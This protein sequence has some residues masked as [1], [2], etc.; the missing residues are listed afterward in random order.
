MSQNT[1][2][3]SIETS[4]TNVTAG[5]TVIITRCAWG[6]FRPAELLALIA[7]AR[8]AR[9]AV[10]FPV[11]HTGAVAA[12]I[13]GSAVRVCRALLRRC[14]VRQPEAGQCQSGK[15]NSEFLQRR[16]PR[17]RLRQALGQFIELV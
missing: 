15:A 6:Q 4:K 2:A 10:A 5:E 17:E 9:S 12:D 13:A 3:Q 14:G 7:A 16:T 11:I 1:P 8:V